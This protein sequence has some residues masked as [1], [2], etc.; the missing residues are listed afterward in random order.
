MKPRDPIWGFYDKITE[1]Y[2]AKCK[3][4][5]CEVS[6]KVERLKTHLQK[7]SKAVQVSKATDSA[8]SSE[9]C[10]ADSANPPTTLKRPSNV[11]Q[12]VLTPK[13]LQQQLLNEFTLQTS[14]SARV[15][16]DEQKARFFFACNVPFNVAESSCSV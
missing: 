11:E 4:C 7:C 10:V 16:L 13:R 6:A 3:A 15:S 8:T 5:S 2:K 14:D 1:E 12:A 9:V